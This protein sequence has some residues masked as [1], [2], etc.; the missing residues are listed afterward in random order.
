MSSNIDLGVFKNSKDEESQSS[1]GV[2]TPDISRGVDRSITRLDPFGLPL[3]PT[4][5]DDEFDP[6]NW[7]KPRRYAILSIACLGNFLCIYITVNTV[8][9]FFIL[10]ELL[11]TTYSEINWTMAVSSLGIIGAL[12]L[13]T[14]FSQIY[15][16]RKV[17]L[18]SSAVTCIVTG[19]ITIKSL[20]K[21]RTL[22]FGFFKALPRAPW[23]R[24]VL[25]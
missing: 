24:R 20:D 5:T 11:D 9:N 14:P 19:C 21:T 6:L 18:L 7:S 10:M 4:P 22:L 15:G 2:G 25:P 3:Q 16:R 12:L 23:R 13:F 1:S 8:Q 17:M